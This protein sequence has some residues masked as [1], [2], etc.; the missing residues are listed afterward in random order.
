MCSQLLQKT[1]LTRMPDLMQEGS[2]RV[3]TVIL[4]SKGLV[5]ASNVNITYPECVHKAQ[6][7]LLMKGESQLSEFW[8]S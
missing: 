1:R 8:N 4:L 7:T 2:L 6:K 3:L 5:K